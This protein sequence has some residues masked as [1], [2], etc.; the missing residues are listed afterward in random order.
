MYDPIAYRHVQYVVGGYVLMA[1]RVL[2]TW[3]EGLRRWVP[4]GGQVRISHGEYPHEAVV[5]QVEQ[6]CGLRVSVVDR[7]RFHVRDAIAHPVPMPLAIQELDVG[8]DVHYLDMA[9]MCRVIGGNVQL[10]Y[11]EAR[12]YHWFNHDD[13]RRFPLLDHV[14]SYSL[15]VLENNPE[16]DE[17]GAKPSL[18]NEHGTRLPEGDVKGGGGSGEVNEG[19]RDAVVLGSSDNR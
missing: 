8:S 15:Y 3:H 7:S 12:A 4:P 10:N 17:L 2:L 1:G 18:S 14:R 9:Y 6:E 16:L 5:R 11:R 13:L 19:D